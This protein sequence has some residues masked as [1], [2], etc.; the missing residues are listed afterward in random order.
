MRR[1]EPQFLPHIAMKVAALRGSDLDEVASQ[2][3]RN[4][5]SF[6]GLERSRDS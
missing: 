4:A 2:S 1:N 6:F 5:I 3:T